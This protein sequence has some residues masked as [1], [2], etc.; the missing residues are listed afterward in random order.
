MRL[1]QQV[2]RVISAISENDS[3]L[4]IIQG[5]LAADQELAMD[6]EFMQQEKEK[7]QEVLR[8]FLNEL[9]RYTEASQ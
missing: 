7:H 9:T 1:D 4:Q 5:V 2:L 8:R 6:L 3:G